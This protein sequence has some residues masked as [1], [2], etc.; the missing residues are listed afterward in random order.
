MK[1]RLRIG[2]MPS[3]SLPF[4]QVRC[5]KCNQIIYEIDWPAQSHGSVVG[6]VMLLLDEINGHYIMMHK[7]TGN[8]FTLLDEDGEPEK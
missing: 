8:I 5:E 1:R 7:E 6:V 3:S 4:W 2:N